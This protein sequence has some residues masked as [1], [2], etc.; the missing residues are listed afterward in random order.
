MS[1]PAV[2]VKTSA[3]A[4]EHI[5]AR[6]GRLYVWAS[7]NA[8]CGGTRFIEASTEP[9]A[10]ADTFFPIPVAGFQLFLRPTGLHGFPEELRVDLGGLRR[11]RVRA[12][13]NDCAYL[14]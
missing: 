13:W 12:Y 11:R 2:R 10:D 9:P 5:R 1:A 6:G 8:C 14:L 4:A 3:S 7:A